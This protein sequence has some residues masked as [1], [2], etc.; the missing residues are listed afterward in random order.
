MTVVPSMSILQGL[1]LI[2]EAIT[3]S[4][5]TLRDTID[6]VHLISIELTNSVPVYR[7]SVPIIVISNMN[8]ELVSP[9]GLNLRAWETLVENLA[10]CFLEPI[11]GKLYKR[12]G[13]VCLLVA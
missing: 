12:A 5:W 9:A 2:G 4:N 7:S 3:L 8:D 1:P 10:S 13:S 11:C 6:T